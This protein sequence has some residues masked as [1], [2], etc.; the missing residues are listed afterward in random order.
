MSVHFNYRM[1]TLDRS[2]SA[3]ARLMAKCND[4]GKD[5]ECDPEAMYYR[6]GVTHVVN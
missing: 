3:S 2:E 4:E 6:Y 1:A 5:I